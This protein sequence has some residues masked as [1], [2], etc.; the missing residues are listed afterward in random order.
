MQIKAT[1]LSLLFIPL[2]ACAPMKID[3]AIQAYLDGDYD[4]AFSMSRDLAQD[5]YPDAQNIIGLIYMNGHGSHGKSC[6]EA[7]KWIGAS[8][9]QN[10]PPAINN[11]GLLHEYGCGVPK[12]L[13]EAIKFYKIADRRGFK[14]ARFNL[15][16][17]GVLDQEKVELSSHNISKFTKNK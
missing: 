1:I 15:L 16:R 6:D 17:L 8:A 4:H 5:G 13:D 3:S 12:N 10:F 11:L 2:V 9:E 14:D 7:I